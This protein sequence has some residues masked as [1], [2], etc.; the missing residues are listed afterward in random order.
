MEEHKCINLNNGSAFTTYSGATP[1][2]WNM[3]PNSTTLSINQG[4]GAGDRIGN[5]IRIVKAT[6]RMIILPAQYDAVN[7]PTPMPMEV[8]VLI[9]RNK[10]VP[11]SSPPLATIFQNG[12]SYSAPSGGIYDNLSAI[13]RDTWTLY[14][15][16]TYKIG[17]SAYGNSGAQANWQ[18]MHN[19]DFK[20][21]AKIK[22]DVTKYLPKIIKYSDTGT[23]TMNPYTWMTFLPVAANGTNYAP[24]YTNTVQYHYEI[25]FTDA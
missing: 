16:K 15:D 20:L 4:T 21:N 22:M 23:A 5:Q 2:T 1:Y 19:N 6:L 9:A 11:Q 7:N 10:Q 8:R 24:A 25:Q 13:N 18:N 12:N 14:S 3:S 17:N